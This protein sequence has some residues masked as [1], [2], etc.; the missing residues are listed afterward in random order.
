[1]FDLPIRLADQVV[2]VGRCGAW[3]LN[4][5]L[6][7]RVDTASPEGKSNITEVFG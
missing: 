3:V 2:G 7:S 6:R 1:M 5:P 4:H